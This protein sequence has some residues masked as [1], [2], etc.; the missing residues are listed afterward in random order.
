VLIGISEV[1]DVSKEEDTVRPKITPCL[2]FDDSA[3]EAI[4]FYVSIFKNS[5]ILHVQRYTEAGPGVP[6]TVL[7]ISFR[8]DGQEFEA[9]N[10]GPYFKFTEAISFAIDCESQE[11]VD[12][13][14]EKLTEGGEP[15]QRG[16][17]KDKYVRCPRKLVQ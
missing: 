8:L 12:E 17:L 13:L 16:W 1:M 2:W 9:I 14:W 3:E 6:G 4:N 11:E 15:S 10:G 5:E 7:A